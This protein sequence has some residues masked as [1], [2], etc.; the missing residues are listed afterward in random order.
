MIWFVCKQCGKPM[1][2]PE[3]AAGSLVFCECGQANRVPWESTLA[4]APEPP[5]KEPQAEEPARPRRARRPEIVPRDPA[6]CFNHQDIAAEQTCADCD[7]H[8]CSA[9]VVTL[10]GHTLCGPCKNY[11]LAKLQRSRSISGMAIGSLAV[12]LA[13]GPFGCCL[14]SMGLGPDSEFHGLAIVFALASMLLPTVAV[15]LGF[16]ALREIV[17]KPS[18][19]GQ[20]IAIIGAVTGVVGVVA[21]VTLAVAIIGKPLMD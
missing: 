9:C 3:N 16:L 5:A 10:G 7:E 21:S 19:G 15:A 1:K 11:R 2:R 12:A 18:V 8:F 13:G 17:R 14:S 6:Y 20:T 4:P